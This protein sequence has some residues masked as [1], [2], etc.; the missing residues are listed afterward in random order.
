MEHYQTLG[1]DRNAS[2]D[3]IKKA[4]RRLAGQHHPDKGGDTATFQKIQQAYETL[5]DPQKKQEYDNP[6]PFGGMP[7]GGGPFRASTE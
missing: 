3:D 7:G 1:V 5:S 4:Y 2:P 6:N